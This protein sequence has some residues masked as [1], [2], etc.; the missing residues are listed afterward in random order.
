MTHELHGFVS[1]GQLPSTGEVER[2]VQLAYEEYQALDDGRVSDVY[3]ALA[4]VD[5]T[6]FGICL[7]GAS[8]RVFAE[9]EAEHVFPIMSVAKPFVFA[10][11]CEAIGGENLRDL[12]GVNSTGYPFNS[13]AAIERDP[14]GRTNPMVN[15]GAIAT[16]S[17]APGET[18]EERWRFIHSGL[19]RFAGRDLQMMDAVLES[20]TA[21]NFRNRAITAALQGVGRLYS[22]PSEALALY[23]QACSLG[24]T[25]RDLAVMGA[26]LADGGV[27]P[28]TGEVVV[29]PVTCHYTLAVMVTAGMYE[30]SG[31]WLF[32]TGLPGKSGIGGGIVTVAPGKGGLGTYSPP[33][34]PAGNSVR[35]KEVA[36]FLSRQLGLGLFV[37]EPV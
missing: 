18:R 21:T 27:N 34:D 20:A 33:L 19:S 6:L 12:V 28:I 8:G 25:A 32:T 37:S 3:P 22:D 5:P 24:V 29:D 10:L 15:S 35:G 9:G 14:D 17:L 7:V 23:T 26:T 30:G 36:A 1:T 13:L 2:L 4:E 16:V 11:V 31:D